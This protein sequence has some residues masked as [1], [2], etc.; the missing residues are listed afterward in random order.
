[1]RPTSG[2]SALALTLALASTTTVATAQQ[3]TT[4]DLRATVVSPIT[5]FADADLSMGLGF[6]GT[7]AY[8]LQPHLHLYGGWDWIRFHSDASFA[9]TDMDFEETGYTLGLRFQHPLRRSD[10]IWCRLEGGALYKHI[11]IEDA[12]GDLIDD[13]GHGL[14]FELGAGLSMAFGEKWNV[15][16]MARLRSHAPSFTIGAITTDATM[17]YVGV[18][19]GFSRRF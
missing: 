16:P 13:S 6:G 11:E 19:L 12:D 7:I 18:E 14:G 4:L 17:R 8:R 15:V 1:M 10:R 5:D 9:G 2:L 3:R